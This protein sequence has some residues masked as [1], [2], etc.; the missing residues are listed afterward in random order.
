MTSKDE[1]VTYADLIRWCRMQ[2]EYIKGLENKIKDMTPKSY[3]TLEWDKDKLREQ[4]RNNDKLIF[5]LEEYIMKI[6]DEAM[7]Y[8]QEAEWYQQQNYELR[9]KK[10]TSKEALKHLVERDFNTIIA[11]NGLTEVDMTDLGQYAFKVI[12]EDL[13]LAE[14]FKLF[15]ENENNNYINLTYGVDNKL[16]LDG[17][18]K[19]SNDKQRELVKKYAKNTFND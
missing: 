2:E 4:L 8:K 18:I 1:Q 7:S 6:N 16:Y 5:A 13:E 10:M 12:E 19:Y 14:L 11:I 15:L 3:I 17:S 9:K